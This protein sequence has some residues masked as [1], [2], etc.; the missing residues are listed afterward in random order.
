LTSS[1]R[2]MR[3]APRDAARF[4]MTL[5]KFWGRYAVPW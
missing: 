2:Q 1:F 5:G 3:H 4:E